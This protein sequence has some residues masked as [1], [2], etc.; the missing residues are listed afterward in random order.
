MGLR[1]DLPHR[2]VLARPGAAELKALSRFG[3][4]VF[5]MNSTRF[6]LESA[7]LVL[8]GRFL[9]P[10]SSAIWSIVSR[11][12]TCLRDLLAQIQISAA[13]A[14]YDLIAKGERARMNQ[15][16]TRLSTLSLSLGL[17]LLSMFAAWDPAFVFLWTSGKCTSPSYLPLS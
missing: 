2:L 4:A 5:R 14:F 17:V 8:A 1:R 6:L 10:E 7:P 3:L 13:P 12:G 11:A 16:F 15:A 9:G